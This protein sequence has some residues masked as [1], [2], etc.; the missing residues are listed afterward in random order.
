MRR[1]LLTVIFAALVG[2]GPVRAE[3]PKSFA[4]SFKTGLAR[5][6]EKGRFKPEKASPVAFEIGEIDAEKQTATL[7]RGERA[8][9]LRVVRAVNALH[10]MEVV[11]EGYLNLTT[12]YDRDAGATSHP[13]VHSRHF[14]VLG[15][16]VVGHY[17]GHCVGR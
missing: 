5:T 9:A 16:P 11:G 4:C 13:A 10:F 8:T 2:V 12:V 6:Y 14:G 3:E 17:Q 15:Q 1:V 7:R